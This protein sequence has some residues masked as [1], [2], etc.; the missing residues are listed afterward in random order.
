MLASPV[1]SRVWAL[2]HSARVAAGE[3]YWELK[4]SNETLD[5]LAP[6]RRRGFWRRLLRL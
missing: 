3:R 6:A 1:S 2:D 4:D 5:R